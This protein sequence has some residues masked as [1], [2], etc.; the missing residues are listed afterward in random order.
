[1]SECYVSN[2]SLFDLGVVWF[3]LSKANLIP[4][5]CFLSRKCKH[6]VILEMYGPQF[7]NS[8]EVWTFFFLHTTFSMKETLYIYWYCGQSW[9][10]TCPYCEYPFSCLC[11]GP[12]TFR[13]RSW[14]DVEAGGWRS[15]G[16]LLPTCSS[17]RTLGVFMPKVLL[18]RKPQE[19]W[20]Q[21]TRDQ[22][23]I[24]KRSWY[25]LLYQGFLPLT[26]FYW[27]MWARVLVSSWYSS[28]LPIGPRSKESNW[29]RMFLGIIEDTL[30]TPIKC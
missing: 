16:A 3:F 6:L 15:Q 20:Q 23:Y 21:V 17:R 5:F 22:T 25:D 9:K 13:K 4:F 30:E 29:F 7:E 28:S 18:P 27:L 1:M 19:S 8:I 14:S 12:Y 10:Q 11:W 2:M 26:S 24:L